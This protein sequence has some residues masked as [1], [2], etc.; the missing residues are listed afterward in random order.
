MSG[1][2]KGA[3]V[4]D[5]YNDYKPGNRSRTSKPCL[6]S[7]DSTTSPKNIANVF[8]Y[9][10]EQWA[11]VTAGQCQ[12]LVEGELQPRRRA[13]VIKNNVVQSSTN[14]SLHNE[15]KRDR[16]ENIK[17]LKIMFLSARCHNYRCKNSS[18]CVFLIKETTQN[19]F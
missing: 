1:A 14:A 15:T 12:K 11:A 6:E 7:S 4:S 10:R 17:C 2:T 8:K 19:I 13:A 18:D 5:K 9:V 3:L 16:K